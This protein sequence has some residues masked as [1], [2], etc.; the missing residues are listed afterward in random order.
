M[1]AG[2]GV[3]VYVCVCVRQEVGTAAEA[4]DHD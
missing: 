3:C 1:D 4:E 2:V